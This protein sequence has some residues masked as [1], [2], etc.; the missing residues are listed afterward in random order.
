MAQLKH[1]KNIRQY[2]NIMGTFRDP[3]EQRERET[4]LFPSMKSHQ[5]AHCSQ[6]TRKAKVCAI[7]KPYK[8]E[9]YKG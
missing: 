9:Y 8:N 7:H 3:Q 5:A 6:G 4:A 2:K 1:F